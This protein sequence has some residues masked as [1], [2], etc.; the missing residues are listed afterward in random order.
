MRRISFIVIMLFVFCIAL[1]AD[2][3]INF[4]ESE[5]SVPSYNVTN[6][7]SSVVTFEL[8]VP[9]M[10]STDIDNYNR[11]YF[12]EHSRMDSVGFPEVPFVSYLIAIPQCD[13]VNLTITLIDSIVIDN[14]NIYPAPEW[15][16]VNNGDYTYLEEQFT[17][18]S[19]FYNSDEY[20][21]SNIGELV[22]KGAVREQHCIRIKI[23]PVQFNPVQQ[24]IIAYSRLNIEMTFDNAVGSVNT[25]TGIFSE[26]CGNAMINYVSNGMNASVNSDN[27]REGSVCWIEDPVNE[28][29]ND[30][31][32]PICDYLIVTHE[33]FY[34]DPDAR[35][36]IEEVLAEKRATYNGFDVVIVK[37]I[38]I[39][40]QIQGTY[41]DD[42][43]RNLIQNTFNINGIGNAQNTFDGRLGCV[44]LFG[45]ALFEDGTQCVPTHYADQQF[46]DPEEGGYDVYFSRLTL[47][48]NGATDVYP[49]I[50]LG[51]CSVDSEEEVTN[52]CTKI[53]EYEPI[54][55][56]LPPVGNYDYWKDR[57][58]FVAGPVGEELLWPYTVNA[59]I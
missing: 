36:Q 43:I 9:G 7:Q 58:T 13:N 37:M 24:L 35:Y 53:E 49:D 51:R 39:I 33:N 48:V 52:V 40:N 31:I 38:D 14:M 16:K 4:D 18:N 17:I 46:P 50:L 57:M 19:T 47:G 3:W 20:F 15:V 44:L 56:R 59:S 41:I 10:N 54:D 32:N 34:S 26:V 29:A 30:Y 8:E 25:D 1:S 5:T 22:E 42:K 2:E 55:V 28:L 6:S 11:V 21:P 45:D 12:P 27:N 23:Y